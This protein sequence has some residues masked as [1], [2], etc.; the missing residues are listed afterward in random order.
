M[1][2]NEAPEIRT[3]EIAEEPAE[4]YKILKFDN[5]V[6]SGG[7]AKF[8]ISEG[9]VLVN[10]EVETRKRKKISVG[11]VIEFQDEKITIVLA[12]D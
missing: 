7:Q 11:D 2:E 6:E 8:V 1:M 3:V 5:M 4:L 10:G 9:L 12:Q